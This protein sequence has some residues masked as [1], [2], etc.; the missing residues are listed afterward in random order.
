MIVFDKV[1]TKPTERNRQ[2]PAVKL[3]ERLAKPE[4]YGI[5]GDAKKKTRANRFDLNVLSLYLNYIRPKGYL[6]SGTDELEKSDKQGKNKEKKKVK[7]VV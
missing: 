5:M 2:R 3:A 7:M 1:G 4:R 6:T